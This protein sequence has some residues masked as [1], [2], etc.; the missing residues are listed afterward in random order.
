MEE[1]GNNDQTNVVD[2]GDGDDNVAAETL[3]SAYAL[4]VLLREGKNKEFIE[5][6]GV[7]KNYPEQDEA[8]L[9]LD[10]SKISKGKNHVF[11]VYFVINY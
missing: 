9:L 7:P 11:E 8:Q 1:T 4:K 10:A 6:L 2:E 3:S 5:A